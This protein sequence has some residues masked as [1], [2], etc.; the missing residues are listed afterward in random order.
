MNK[1][2]RTTKMGTYTVVIALV[3]LAAIIF[4]NMIVS[5]LPS[6]Y[7]IID[8]SAEKLYSISE[9]S[10]KAI[11]N[12]EDDVVI[13]YLCS[14]GV[15]DETFR[16]F[17]D[18]YASAN[19]KIKIKVVDPVEAPAFILKYTEEEV[20][21]FS[22][23]IESAKRFKIIDY[24]DIYAFDYYSYYYY[25][26]ES[27][28]FNGERLI[29]S[30][31]DYVTTSNMPKIYNLTGHQENALE[32]TLKTQMIDL[33][34]SLTDLSLL[35]VDA[36]PD[37]ASAVIVNVPAAD[38][39]ED[40]AKK[41]KAYLD[42]GGKVFL[43][44][45]AFYDSMPN[46]LSVTEYYGLTMAHGLIIEGDSAKCLSG[47]P[48]GLLPDIQSHSITDPLKDSVIIQVPYAHP[49]LQ[50]ETLRDGVTISNL[51]TTS[52]K[53][54]TVDPESNANNLNKTDDSLAGPFNIGAVAT[55]NDKG[56]LV[57]IA[58]DYTFTD[59]MN[60][61][62]SGANYQYFLSVIKNLSPRDTIITDIP[63]VTLEEPVLTVTEGQA[64]FWSTVL[65]LVIPFA[66]IAI[67]VL[68]WVIRRR[69]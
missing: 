28:T 9:Q 66:F 14:G 6:K 30:A 54:Y 25:G 2:R 62:S 49:I 68:K 4:V 65:T 22:L 7:T 44:T 56:T 23:I 67:G 41:L 31:L 59:Y 29:T 1:I 17:L 37:D 61:Y 18:R 51:F 40:D 46:L 26:T 16:T 20:S 33:N 19:P 48:Y 36:V 58:S 60:S 8:T 27:Y 43:I 10:E 34:Y 15:E 13:N 52:D 42:K 47:A 45:S 21:N 24:A 63:S 64:N 53:A 11:R 5:A 39:N 38:I 35:T 12:I 3:V 57:W 55:E 50:T 69:K 32:E